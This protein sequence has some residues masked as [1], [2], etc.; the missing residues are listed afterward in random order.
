MTA[1]W[2]TENWRP[3]VPIVTSL[4]LGLRSTWWVGTASTSSS[5]SYRPPCSPSPPGS[6]SSSPRPATPPGKG[7]LTPHFDIHSFGRT[8]LLVTV[9]LC[10]IGIFTTAIQ[11]TPQFDGGKTGGHDRNLSLPLLCR[12][13]RPGTLVFRLHHLHLPLSDQLRHHSLHS[14]LSPGQHPGQQWSTLIGPDP[15]RYSALIGWDHGAATPA[16]LCH[17]DTAQGI[18]I[19]FPVSLWHKM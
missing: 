15:S 17:R 3:G 1:W 4:Q 12:N 8:T 19:P 14:R 2:A 5:T 9:F 18:Q 7:L 11:D 6:P 16:L 10:Q 13:D